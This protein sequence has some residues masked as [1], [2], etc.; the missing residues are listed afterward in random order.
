[1]S[2]RIWFKGW[3]AADSP[4]TREALAAIQGWRA[5]RAT[6]FHLLRAVRLYAALLRGD[7]SVLQELFPFLLQQASGR[8]VAA[9]AAPVALASADEQGDKSSDDFMDSLGMGGLEF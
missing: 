7:V 8:Y 5:A 1:M 3:K 2:S 9:M 4:E 6:P